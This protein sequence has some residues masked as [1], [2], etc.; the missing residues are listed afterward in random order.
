[1]RW[2][3]GRNRRSN[4]DLTSHFLLRATRRFVSELFQVA[5]T[6]RTAV[7]SLLR[8][9]VPTRTSSKERPQART[10]S[11]AFSLKN[12]PAQ[13]KFEAPSR[14]VSATFTRAFKLAPHN[15]SHRAP[16]L[17]PFLTRL[18]NHLPCG[19]RLVSWWLCLFR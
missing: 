5:R 4:P 3:W 19:A 7:T 12:M 16:K 2:F 10:R 17:P 14:F 6:T 13:E 9:L 15:G 8:E 1:M 11:E 18:L